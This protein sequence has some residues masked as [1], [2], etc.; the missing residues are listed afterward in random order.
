VLDT[1]G[2]SVLV[3]DC[4]ADDFGSKTAVVLRSY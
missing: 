4:V 3:V 1:I 2:E